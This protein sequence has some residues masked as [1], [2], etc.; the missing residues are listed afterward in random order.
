MTQKYT[1]KN[2]YIKVGVANKT[3]T[4]NHPEKKTEYKVM[5]PADRDQIMMGLQRTMAD[6]R[7]RWRKLSMTIALTTDDGTTPWEER[8]LKCLCVKQ[9]Q[10]LK[11]SSKKTRF[12]SEMCDTIPECVSHSI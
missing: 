5:V 9:K 1:I 4:W 10:Y 3:S 6:D 7:S 11:L 12:R 8:I 2:E